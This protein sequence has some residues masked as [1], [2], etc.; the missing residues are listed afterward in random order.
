M[1]ATLYFFHCE[2]ET[3]FEY[4]IKVYFALLTQFKVYPQYFRNEFNNHQV[5]W[6]LGTALHQRRSVS[7]HP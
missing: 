1:E 7:Y 5:I 2:I 4:K 3:K 6:R